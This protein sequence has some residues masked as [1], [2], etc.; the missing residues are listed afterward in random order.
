MLSEVGKRKD[1]EEA[2]DKEWRVA[3][4]KNDLLNFRGQSLCVLDDDV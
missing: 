4:E 2:R 1:R 3:R